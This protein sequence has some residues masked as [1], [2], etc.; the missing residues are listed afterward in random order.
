MGV[1]TFAWLFL[2][3]A[4]WVRLI[5]VLPTFGLETPA[6]ESLAR[7]W[8]AM[9]GH[10]GFALLVSA[11]SVVPLLVIEHFGN[12]LY[13]MLRDP[14]ENFATAPLTMQ[15]CEALLVVAVMLAFRY[16]IIASLAAWIYRAIVVR[17]STAPSL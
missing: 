2:V 10:F 12:K 7:A 11:M 13:R 8:R 14:G 1:P 9:R 3:S 5:L 17:K 16:M 15:Q 6:R 4:I